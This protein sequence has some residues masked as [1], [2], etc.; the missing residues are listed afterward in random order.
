MYS[1]WRQDGFEMLMLFFGEGP[2]PSALRVQTVLVRELPAAAGWDE[3]PITGPSR[4]GFVLPALKFATYPQRRQ[5]SAELAKPGPR[6]Q[7][8][9]CIVCE[10]PSCG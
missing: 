5:G 6:F 10:V 3:A 2:C 9:A 1:V 7:F 4:A 8:G